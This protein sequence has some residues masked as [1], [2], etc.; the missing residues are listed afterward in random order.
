[1]AFSILTLSLGILLQIFG[2]GAD[3]AVTSE[4]YTKAILL[5]E[6][7]LAGV[8]LVEELEEGEIQGTTDD[9]YD[10]TIIVEPYEPENEEIVMDSLPIA[11]YQ[12][13]VMIRWGDSD[14]PRSVVL[15]TLRFG[16][17]T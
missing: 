10:W 6:S 17:S 3:L 4:G 16:P 5:A 12:V 1:M 15:K 7:T 11:V 14:R 9:A 2:K 8:G 13:Q